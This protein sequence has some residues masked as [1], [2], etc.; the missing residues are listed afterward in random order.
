ME[1]SHSSLKRYAYS[2]NTLRSASCNMIIYDSLDVLVCLNFSPSG[3]V[4]RHSF[5]IYVNDLSISFV[6]E[7]QALLVLSN[8]L[9]L[10]CDKQHPRNMVQQASIVKRKHTCTCRFQTSSDHGFIDEAHDANAGLAYFACQD[11]TWWHSRAS[12]ESLQLHLRLTLDCPNCKR[13]GL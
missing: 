1:V 12:P 2:C 6:L 3:V 9:Q 7:K 10:R 4:S 13:T 5:W 8:H 11:C